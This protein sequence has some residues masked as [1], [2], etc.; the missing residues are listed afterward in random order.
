MLKEIVAFRDLLR[1]LVIIEL[2]LRYRNN[3]LGFLW[4]ILNPL[5]YLLIL[6]IVFSQLLRFNIPHY[7]IFLLSGLTS[8]MMLQQTIVIATASIVNNQH[9]IRKVYI[10]KILFP[11]SNVL[12]RYVD[13]L[14]LTV[15]LFLFMIGLKAHF[16]WSLLLVAVAI[17][18]H[19]F[20]TLGLS[21]LT[22]V[23]YIRVRDVQQIV[24]VL[25]QALFYLTPIIYSVEAL[26]ESLRSL[27]L[28]NP[29]YYFVQVFRYP[30]YYGTP[31]PADILTVA[32]II[33]VLT[34]A[35]GLW[36]FGRKEKY[37]VFSLS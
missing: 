7:T 1:N 6:A 14:A 32:F 3:V 33:T 23:A 24:A 19:F 22:A 35:A 9:L 11:L 5:F 36:L 26:P 37:F 15:I 10:P 28:L 27:F 30:V 8:W 17:L 18:L 13:H 16:S 4:T 31:P 25:F 20:F 12:A 21:L 29:F 2:K 34:F